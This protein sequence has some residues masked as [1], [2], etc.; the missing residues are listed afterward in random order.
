MTKTPIISDFFY[1]SRIIP[2]FK[3]VKFYLIIL[4]IISII[5]VV[6]NM[7][8][9]NYAEAN[10]YAFIEKSTNQKSRRRGVSL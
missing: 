1:V 5:Y 3:C 8:I 7:V 2:F 10:N 4:S 6:D 9:G